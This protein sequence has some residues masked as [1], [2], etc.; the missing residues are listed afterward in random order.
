MNETNIVWY[1]KYLKEKHGIDI[2]HCQVNNWA[3][4]IG[5]SL[6]RC[7]QKYSKADPAKLVY[8]GGYNGKAVLP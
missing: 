7:R 1:L 4:S 2:K 8:S 3:H 6:Q 5:F